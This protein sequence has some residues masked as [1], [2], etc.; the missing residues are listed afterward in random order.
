LLKVNNHKYPKI[1]FKKTIRD[2]KNFLLRNNF[3][4]V[5]YIHIVDDKGSLVGLFL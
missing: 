1:N 2:V 3:K 5:D 4:S